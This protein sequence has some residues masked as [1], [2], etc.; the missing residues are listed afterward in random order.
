MARST[1]FPLIATVHRSG[2][3]RRRDGRRCHTLLVSTT[4]DREMYSEAAAA[5]LLRLAP[6][7][8]HYWL[9]GGQGKERTYPPVIREQ[10]TGSKRV[11][12]AEFVEAGLLREYRRDL[13]IPMLELRRFIDALRERLGIAYP[14][15]HERPY[16]AGRKLVIAAQKQA[17]LRPEFAL[18]AEVSGQFVLTGPAD[19]FLRRVT[20]T[21]ERPA[22]WRPDERADSPVVVDPDIRFGSPSVRGV[23]TAAL[24]EQLQAGEDEADLASTFGLTVAQVRWAVSFE[25][26]DHAA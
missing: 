7:T 26:A 20:W 9:E 19:A 11:T 18:V 17:D 4:L 2:A 10:A 23:S 16:A 14:L 1:E 12:W 5:R 15:A 24:W 21:D 8:L 13:K 6:S 22:A 25:M 3:L